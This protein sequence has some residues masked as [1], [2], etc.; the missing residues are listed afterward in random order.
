MARGDGFIFGCLFGFLL[1]GIVV[2]LMIW[3]AW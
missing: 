2:M 1:A 3:A